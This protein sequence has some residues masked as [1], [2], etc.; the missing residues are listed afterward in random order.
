MT[1]KELIDKLQEL[2]NTYG[3]LEVICYNK[4]EECDGV[5]SDI[6]I[7]EVKEYKTID[8]YTYKSPSYYCRGDTVMSEEDIGTKFIVIRSY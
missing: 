4:S 1:V 5:T 6:S 2:S 8:G 7:D 3:D